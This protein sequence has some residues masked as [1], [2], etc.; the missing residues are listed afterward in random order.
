[1]SKNKSKKIH[2]I[3]TEDELTNILNTFSVRTLSGNLD[4]E[5][6]N[7]ARKLNYALKQCESGGK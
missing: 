7:L 6:K 1:M 3:L 5:D 2:V 4:D